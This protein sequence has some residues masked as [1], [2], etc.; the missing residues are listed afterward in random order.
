MSDDSE[1][2]FYKGDLAATLRMHFQK[3]REKVDAIPEGQFLGNDDAEIIAHVVSDMK[4]QA[5]E[6]HEDAMSMH[7]EETRL[8]VNEWGMPWLG[9]PI[10]GDGPVRVPAQRVTI[11][12]PYSGDSVLWKLRP[13]NWQPSFPRGSVKP[14]KGDSGVLEIVMEQP[15]THPPEKYKDHLELTLSEIRYYL[16]HQ[17]SQIEQA[18]ASL[19]ELVK[20]A[21]SQR[22]TRLEKH[23]AVQKLLNI[24]LAPRSGAPDVTHLPIRQKLVKPLPPVPNHPPEYGIANDRYE[25]ILSVIR[26]E[27]RTYEATPV[28]FA[29]HDE[30]E[31]RDIILAHLNGHYHGDATGEVFRRTG[32]TDIRIEADNRAAFVAECK[33]WRGPRELSAAVDQLLG[34]L[35]WRDC[36][37]SLIIFNK[38]ISGFSAIQEKVPA[39]LRAHTQ[40]A[41][42]VKLDQAGEWRFTFRAPDDANRLITIHVFL[43]NL[44]VAR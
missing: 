2:L 44:Y 42:D 20:E 17:K 32:K 22:R 13:S 16:G 38:E 23:T 41:G 5:L 19:P 29:K 4:V 27:G 33:V 7:Q 18:N 21:V 37:A 14:T 40:F 43:F 26:H 9:R 35:T 39:E 31:L 25:H 34:Y 6:L 30:E 24:P 10:A 1:L 36:K 8:D 28:T 3:T 12:L 11:S 15:S